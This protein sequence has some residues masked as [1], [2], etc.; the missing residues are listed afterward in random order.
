MRSLSR[1]KAHRQSML[2][3]LATSLILYERIETT[4]AKAKEVKP[5]VEH[6]IKL[7]RKND[8]TSR[9]R[10]F[11]FLLDENAVR[12][13]FEVYVPSYKS[14]KSG[15]IKVYKKGLRKG[16]AAEIS[17]LELEKIKEEEKEKKDGEK[18]NQKEKTGARS[19]AK[20]KTKTK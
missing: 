4:T 16:D 7:A 20:P 8:L 6:L 15:F 19:K 2:R 3:N 10:L 14:K 17:I 1:K 9:R 18:T 11:S 13:V 12:K 5:I